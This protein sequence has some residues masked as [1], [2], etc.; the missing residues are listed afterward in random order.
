MGRLLCGGGREC[1]FFIGSLNGLLFCGLV[2]VAVVGVVSMG[3]IW[4]S[5]L[6]MVVFGLG[7]I[8][9]MMVIVFVG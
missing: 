7:I 4:N 3:V 6:Y 1:L 8:L 9:L 2:Y 5:V